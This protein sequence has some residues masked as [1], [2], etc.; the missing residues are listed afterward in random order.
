MK[1]VSIYIRVST[2]QQ[3]EEGYSIEAQKERLISYCKAKGWNIYNIYV[4][5]GYT[6]SNI[7]RP[8]LEKMMNELVHI[9]VVL[10]YKLDRLSRSQKD[11]LYLIEEKFL[12]NNIDFVSLQENFDTSSAFGRAMI[13]ILSVFAQL[14]RETITERSKM[15]KDAR[16]KKGL[17]KGG[18]PPVG[19]DYANG[20][21][22]INEY[23]AMQVKKIFSWYLEGKGLFTIARELEY[24]GYTKKLGEWKDGQATLINNILSNPVYIG[25]L[26]HK[27]SVI[28]GQHQSIIEI[29]IF[30]EVQRRKKQTYRGKKTE[31]KYILT[32]FL[33]CGYCGARM[34]GNQITTKK[35]KKHYIYIYYTCYSKYSKQKAMVKD[36]NCPS[37]AH[38]VDKLEK[39]VY[40]KI[41]MIAVNK[42]N[43]LEVFRSEV[44]VTNE[45]VVIE[46]KIKDLDKQINKLMDLYQN[47]KI[48]VNVISE[49]IEKLY[50]EKKVLESTVVEEKEENKY[51]FDYLWSII[52]DFELIW[53]EATQE[54]KKVVLES[55]VDNIVVYVDNIEVN[56]LTQ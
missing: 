12:K 17:W 51:D 52:K 10:V 13:G 55:F 46:N 30:E 19:Y 8:A 54:E 3:A 25:K 15:G 4:D 43:L 9:D 42:N 53:Q 36:P 35:G 41:K 11:T 22:V 48:P 24:L 49:R 2:T 31:G 6:G 21:L 40:E 33:R 47:D 39:E 32:G 16:A 38:H 14:E 37:R 28:Q 27:D 45:S 50:D 44:A 34:Y 29:D 18:S 7:E 1:K 20:E 26:N 23:E 56:L 5:G